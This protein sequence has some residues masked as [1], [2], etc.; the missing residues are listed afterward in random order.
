MEKIK[1]YTYLDDR[2][3]YKDTHAVMPKDRWLSR[4]ETVR[5]FRKEMGFKISYTNL[6][7]GLRWLR[8]YGLIKHR[9][10]EIRPLKGFTVEDVL[11]KITHGANTV[12]SGVIVYE[13]SKTDKC[14]EEHFQRLVRWSKSNR[15]RNPKKKSGWHKR[16]RFT[17]EQAMYIRMNPDGLSDYMAAKMFDCHVRTIE[18]IRK[19]KIYKDLDLKKYMPLRDDIFKQIKTE[20]YDFFVENRI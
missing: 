19:G 8:K 3:P 6:D 1:E 15:I 11:R 7:M 4:K 17:P 2:H 16:R 9:I 14:P 13:Y 12:N 5:L 18:D 20:R 10:R